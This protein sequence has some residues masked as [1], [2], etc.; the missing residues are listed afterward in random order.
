MNRNRMHALLELP[1]KIGEAQPNLLLNLCQIFMIKI[2][3]ASWS[4]VEPL[5]CTST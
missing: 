1:L 2:A 3:V 5:Y 4:I